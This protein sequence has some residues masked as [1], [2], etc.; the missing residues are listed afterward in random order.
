MKGNARTLIWI[1]SLRE[2]AAAVESMLHKLQSLTIALKRKQQLGRCSKRNDYSAIAVATAIAGGGNVMSKPT[3][4]TSFSSSIESSSTSTKRLYIGNVKVFSYFMLI[5]YKHHLDK[6]TI[7][8]FFSSG[9]DGSSAPAVSDVGSDYTQN[10]D[11]GNDFIVIVD[12]AKGITT[13]EST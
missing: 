6:S 10:E 5:V 9:N 3:N 7:N 11:S 2:K 4:T 13:K 1:H 12:K 8:F